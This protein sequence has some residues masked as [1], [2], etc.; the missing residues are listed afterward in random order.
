MQLRNNNRAQRPIP[1]ESRSL[2]V[3]LFCITST[4]IYAPNSRETATCLV[5]QAAEQNKDIVIQNIEALLTDKYDNPY[6]G[7]HTFGGD[8]ILT[9]LIANIVQVIEKWT[10]E[11]RSEI[12]ALVAF[13]IIWLKRRKFGSLLKLG[14]AIGFCMMITGFLHPLD[15]VYILL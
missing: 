3:H 13:S 2:R 5:H 15:G 9:L 4:L 6:V 1:L 12:F 8:D 11:V 14:L 7:L 10:M